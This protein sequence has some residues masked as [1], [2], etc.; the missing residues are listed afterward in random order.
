MSFP[1]ASRPGPLA[2]ALAAALAAP[3]SQAQAPQVQLYGLLDLGLRIDDSSAGRISSVVSGGAAGSRIGLRATEDL[4]GGLKASANLEGGFLADSGVFA[5]GGRAWGRRSIVALSGD[6][7]SVEL[8]RQTTPLWRAA[9]ATDAFDGL[10]LGNPSSNVFARHNSQYVRVDNGLWYISPKLHGFALQALWAP[11]ESSGEGVR[12][13]AGSIGSLSLAWSGSGLDLQWAVLR[14]NGATNTPSA[15]A[16]PET[17]QAFGASYKLGDWQLFA[18]GGSAKRDAGTGKG[19]LER[20]DQRSA[21]LSLMYTQGAH[22]VL[23]GWGQLQDKVLAKADTSIVALGYQY[24]LSK[25][26]MVYAGLSKRSNEANAQYLL[27]DAATNGALKTANVAPG[28]DPSAVMVGMR[29][30]F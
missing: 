24:S 26:S 8:G 18:Q 14:N 11:G 19:A 12:G 4:G 9:A 29:H 27:L 7:G 13:S 15:L 10:M 23:L 20:L 2:L 6:F 17:L 25:R 3:A 1:L 5:Q 28:F 21:A 22:R 16:R 30:S